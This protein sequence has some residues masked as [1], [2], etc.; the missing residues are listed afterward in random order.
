MST[1]ADKQRAYRIRKATGLQV[2]AIPVVPHDVINALIE[3]GRL[4]PVDA[5]DRAKVRFAIAGVV[6]DFGQRWR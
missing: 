5:L 3:T 6:A 1:Q 2:Y 4:S